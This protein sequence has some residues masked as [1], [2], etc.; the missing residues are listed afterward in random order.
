MQQLSEDRSYGPRLWR[1]KSKI[2][3][4]IALWGA[5]KV[6]KTAFLA[7]LEPAAKREGLSI[8]S[9]DAQTERIMKDL[10]ETR[11]RHLFPAAT[12]V[13]T[14][15]EQLSC[16]HFGLRSAQLN[17]EISLTLVD[18][19]GRWWIESDTA[20]EKLSGT[21]NPYDA[22][23]SKCIGLLCLID[24]TQAL[25]RAQ[26]PEIAMN[27]RLAAPANVELQSMLDQLH[28]TRV[29]SNASLNTKVAICL[30]QMDRPEHYS[31]LGS[32]EEYCRRLYGPLPIQ[33]WR[34]R[35]GWKFFGCSAVGVL[36]R[37]GYMISNTYRNHEG[38]EGI[39]DPT[40]SPIHVFRPLKWLLGLG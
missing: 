40:V 31:H 29:S 3:A 25:K 12:G 39:L 13:P 26:I 18:A 20:S 8:F 37:A 36:Q 38:Q 17:Q 15:F 5:E 10:R 19:S 27:A 23:L 1:R 9:A 30:A 28:R 14:C 24:P 11:S 34:G 22:I 35:F 33:N 16:V 32:E 4:T 6:G 7:A 21:F 2:D